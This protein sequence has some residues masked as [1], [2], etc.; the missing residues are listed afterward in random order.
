MSYAAP[1]MAP[2]SSARCIQQAQCHLC[3][4]ILD[5][6]TPTEQPEVSQAAVPAKI[7]IDGG[8]LFVSSLLEIVKLQRPI[9]A[10][11]A[12]L[13]WVDAVS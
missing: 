8:F 11:I 4:R 9:S 3:S 2:G 12:F 10:L 1:G 13:Y 7:A 6:V 5:L